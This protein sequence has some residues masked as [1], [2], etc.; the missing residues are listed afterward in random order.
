VKINENQEVSKTWK[1]VFMQAQLAND[2]E[3]ELFTQIL[4]A[5]MEN[6]SRC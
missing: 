3:D 2:E 6:P 5:L 1:L 4:L